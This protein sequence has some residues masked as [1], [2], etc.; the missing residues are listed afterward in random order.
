[1]AAV[2]AGR[3]TFLS[4]PSGA[5]KMTR[6]ISQTTKPSYSLPAPLPTSQAHVHSCSGSGGGGGGGGGGS[7]AGLFRFVRFR[8]IPPDSA[9]WH[10]PST[11][12]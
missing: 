6:L 1:M 8:R 2:G 11:L 9:E 12:S 5:V 3:H 4:R 10:L 7:E